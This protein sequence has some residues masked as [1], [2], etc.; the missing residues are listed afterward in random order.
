MGHVQDNVVEARE[1]LTKPQVL[2]ET[3][4]CSV[5]FEL[6]MYEAGKC[7]LVPQLPRRRDKAL[8][9]ATGPCPNCFLLRVAV[10][11]VTA[12]EPSSAADASLAN[13]HL[14]KDNDAVGVVSLHEDDG[15]THAIQQLLPTFL[16]QS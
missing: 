1:R 16:R 5:E 14:Q 7:T 2:T 3:Q 4:H 15:T 10:L 9:A 12:Y 13:F 6:F 11:Q 8:H